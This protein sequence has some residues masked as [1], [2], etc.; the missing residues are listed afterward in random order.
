MEPFKP[1]MSP[2]LELLRLHSLYEKVTHFINLPTNKFP[3]PLFFP[4]IRISSKCADL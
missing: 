2:L 1:F 4:N 3:C